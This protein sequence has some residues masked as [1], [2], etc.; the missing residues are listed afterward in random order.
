MVLPL[1]PFFHL[2]ET[3]VFVGVQLLLL[4]DPALELPSVIA[5]TRA[6]LKE[7]PNWRSVAEQWLIHG[8]LIQQSPEFYRI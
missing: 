8:D 3:A 1:S 5:I 2:R 6:R 4:K 7:S